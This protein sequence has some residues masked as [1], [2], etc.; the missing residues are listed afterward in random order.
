MNGKGYEYSCLIT[1][2][3]TRMGGWATTCKRCVGCT[4]HPVSINL[5][6]VVALTS[7]YVVL[8]SNKAIEVVFFHALLTVLSALF[9][10]AQDHCRL[11]FYLSCKTYIV[12]HMTFLAIASSLQIPQVSRFFLKRSLQ[13]QRSQITPTTTIHQKGIFKCPSNGHG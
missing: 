1:S 13:E 9:G 12:V 11:C 4:S 6:L 5:F 8:L 3:I 10:S 7:G 2:I